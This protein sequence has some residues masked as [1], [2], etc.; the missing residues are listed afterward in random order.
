MSAEPL[1]FT[2]VGEAQPKGSIKILPRVRRF[3]VTMRTFRDLMMAVVATSDN[4]QVKS[5]QSRIAFEATTALRQAKRT[6]IVGPVS[7]QAEFYL[8][9]PTGLP[10]SYAG[11]HLKKPD[12]DKLLRS[13]LDALTGVVWQDDSQVTSIIA[14]KAYASLGDPPRAVI[15]VRPI[16][17]PLLERT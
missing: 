5:W 6:A 17:P 12:A 2:V 8:P 7:V 9:R 1:M 13:L 14:G 4:P 10:K 16:D 11:P 3:P 15:T